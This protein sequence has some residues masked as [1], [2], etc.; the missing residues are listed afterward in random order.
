LTSKERDVL[1]RIA[2]VARE[3]QQALCAALTDEERDQL[4]VWL[5]RIADEQGLRPGVHPG[6]GR[7][8]R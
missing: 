2:Q 6:F 5:S 4:A 7:L 8:G 3:H 1:K